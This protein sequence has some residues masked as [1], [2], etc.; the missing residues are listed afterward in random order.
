MPILK[1][2]KKKEVWHSDPCYL[3]FCYSLYLTDVFLAKT[4][5]AMASVLVLA[6]PFDT[7][8]GLT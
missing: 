6:K 2:L 1:M 8:D 7:D 4:G 5:I 3:G